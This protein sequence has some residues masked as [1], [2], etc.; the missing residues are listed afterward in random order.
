MSNFN[1]NMKNILGRSNI[2]S[3][4]ALHSRLNE[5]VKF[6]AEEQKIRRW[7]WAAKFFALV[8]AAAIGAVGAVAIQTIFPTSPLWLAA[9]IFVGGL[10]IELFKYWRDNLRSFKIFAVVGVIRDIKNRIYKRELVQL[11][12]F[13]FIRTKLRDNGF[14]VL[15]DDDA[16][17]AQFKKDR[18]KPDLFIQKY[19]LSLVAF[20]KEWLAHRKC[21]KAYIELCF[22]ARKHI[23]A[24]DDPL[25]PW[26]EHFKNQLKAVQAKRKKPN[27]TTLW[28]WW[29]CFYHNVDLEIKIKSVLGVLAGIWAIGNGI[30]FGSLMFMHLQLLFAGVMSSLWLPAVLACGIGV[31]VGIGYWMLMYMLLNKAI[32]KNI[33]WSKILKPLTKLFY[34]KRW[35][36]MTNGQRTFA[37]IKNFIF[38]LLI[39]ALI[40]IAVLVNFASSGTW[41][42]ST[43]SFFQWIG[44]FSQVLAAVF[45]VHASL[46]AG[47]TVLIFM[48]PVAIMFSFE[49][50]FETAKR[51]GRGVKHLWQSLWAE[52]AEEA[53]RQA[54]TF[55]VV[56]KYTILTLFAVALIV[57]FAFHVYGEGGVAGEGVNDK[58]DIF[59]G[60]FD[61]LT[62]FIDKVFHIS[63]TPATLAVI[64][65]TL[66]ESGEDGIFTFRVFEQTKEELFAQN[67]EIVKTR[68][69]KQVNSNKTSNLHRDPSMTSASRAVYQKL[70]NPLYVGIDA[71]AL[72][73][74]G[75][76]DQSVSDVVLP[77]SITA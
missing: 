7:G 13:A 3:L 52:Q 43:I 74:L 12:Q 77:M 40:G 48:T 49:N 24:K 14:D 8:T 56:A 37:L 39:A 36:D 61:K 31:C 26:V 17:F 51:I 68:N 71:T 34:N 75:Q 38:M 10:V 5:N 44:S 29:L 70:F 25:K 1:K 67:G 69:S 58:E 55:K 27:K 18:K 21:I 32:V 50:G 46:F 9:G 66:V 76:T 72:N 64:G 22:R 11:E 15:T 42:K 54:I 30:G 53:K 41:L 2:L 60:I 33:F 28:E 63:M 19:G 73:H 47:V 65:N 16:Q 45:T 23:I 6:R 59:V 62:R 35:S 20:D 4:E 57:A